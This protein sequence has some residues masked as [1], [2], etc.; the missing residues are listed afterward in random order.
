MQR[1]GYCSFYKN[2]AINLQQDVQKEH[3]CLCTTVNQCGEA[4]TK[5]RKNSL[6]CRSEISLK[7]KLI[8]KKVL[9][10]C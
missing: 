10:K 7:C 8:I 2:D 1:F 4:R 3:L 9:N 5:K 6:K